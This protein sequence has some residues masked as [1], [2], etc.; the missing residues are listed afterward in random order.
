[1]ILLLFAKLF[2]FHGEGIEFYQIPQ[3]DSTTFYFIY[4]LEPVEFPIELSNKR[5]IRCI[6]LYGEVRG[7]NDILGAFWDMDTIPAD[8]ENYG[9]IKHI[10]VRREKKYT[11]ESEVSTCHMLKR[12]E[13]KQ[14]EKDLFPVSSL[15]PSLT[16]SIV[17]FAWYF[18]T[19]GYIAVYSEISDTGIL[20]TKREY[21]GPPLKERKVLIKRG[22]NF[23]PIDFKGLSPATYR[24]V[25]SVKKYRRE[26]LVPV[27]SGSGWSEKQWKYMIMAV[28]YIFTREEIDSLENAPLKEKEKLWNKYW[29]RRDPSPATSQNEAYME[30]LRRFRY[31]EEHYRS[32]FG[33]A[34]SDMGIIYITLGPPDEVEKHEFEQNSQP[35]VI[36]Y[37]YRYNLKFRFED[38]FG[39]GDYELVDPPR[40]MLDDIMESIRK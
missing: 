29:A 19:T 22:W 12:F 9:T 33:G 32:I 3:K 4:R 23:I 2:L 39:T 26:V 11:V 8:S 35:Y 18:D 17:K 30:F 40:Y 16:D 1:M 24:F 38:R 5:K 20:K 14:S 28:R 15:I 21:G 37:Y 6:S 7:K 25:L 13:K 27:M 31:A 34:L 36:W 10:R